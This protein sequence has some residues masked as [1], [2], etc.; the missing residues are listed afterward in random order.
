[1]RLLKVKLIFL[2]ETSGCVILSAIQLNITVDQNP[3]GPANV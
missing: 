1:M 3:F 2:F